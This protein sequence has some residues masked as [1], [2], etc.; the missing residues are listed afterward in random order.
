ML[1]C[2]VEMHM[3]K[4]LAPMPFDDEDGLVRDSSVAKAEHSPQALAKAGDGSRIA[5][6]GYRRC[7]RP[8][9]PVLGLANAAGGLFCNGGMQ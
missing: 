4:A 5:Q 9:A 3:R 2:H 8:R 6:P 7:P 1:A